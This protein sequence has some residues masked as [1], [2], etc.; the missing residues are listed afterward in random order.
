[1]P[2]FTKDLEEVSDHAPREASEPDPT[3]FVYRPNNR[4]PDPKPKPGFRYGW[5]RHTFRNEPDANNWMQ[6]M[7]EGWVP[8]K[9]E[10][11]P[12]LSGLQD[13]YAGGPMAKDGY[14]EHRGNVLCIMPEYKAVA[15]EK[16]FEELNR[17]KMADIRKTPINPNRPDVQVSAS[18]SKR[19]GM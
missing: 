18:I 16:Y 13:H 17:R 3:T 11:V 10:S 12:E 15:K 2:K 5:I 7:G 1:M 14:V 6:M 8:V 4:L 9:A 19:L